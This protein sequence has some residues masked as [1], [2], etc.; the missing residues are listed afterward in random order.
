MDV[1]EYTSEVDMKRNHIANWL[2]NM[3]VG[4]FVVGAFQAVE[5][6][7]SLGPDTKW[8]IMTLAIGEFLLSLL[9]AKED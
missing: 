6:V 3:S 4:T 2:S 8:Y 7:S 9:L 5:Q 1:V